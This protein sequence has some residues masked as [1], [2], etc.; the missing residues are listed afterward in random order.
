LVETIND[1]N[2]ITYDST[3]L[4][5]LL[6]YQDS[7]PHEYI[8][9]M[10]DLMITQGDNQFLIKGKKAKVFAFWAKFNRFLQKVEQEKFNQE[11]IIIKFPGEG[12]NFK[13]FE[14]IA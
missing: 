14:S 4:A 8:N 11:K 6:L 3:N 10:D 7:E 5:G 1:E 12:P 13:M 2:P 9:L